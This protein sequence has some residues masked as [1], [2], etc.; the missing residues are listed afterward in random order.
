MAQDGQCE[1]AVFPSKLEA[2]LIAEVMVLISANLGPVSCPPT[3]PPPLALKAIEIK[4][5]QMA[6]YYNFGCGPI[7]VAK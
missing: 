6:G 3:K 1:Q 2:I 5:L 4:S 7:R